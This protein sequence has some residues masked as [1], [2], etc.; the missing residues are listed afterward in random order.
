ME[1]MPIKKVVQGADY[2]FVRFAEQHGEK[3]SRN[4]GG[5]RDLHM[6]RQRLQVSGNRKVNTSGGL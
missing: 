6:V 5:W 4:G 3:H 1:F 2:I